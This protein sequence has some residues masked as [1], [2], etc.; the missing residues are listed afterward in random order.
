MPLNFGGFR[1]GD[2]ASAVSAPGVVDWL[3]LFFTIMGF[4]AVIFGALWALYLH[5]VNKLD[6]LAER[7]HDHEVKTAETVVERQEIDK[8]YLALSD[9]IDAQN[10]RIDAHRNG[11][12]DKP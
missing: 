11:R 1:S 9:R 6:K 7:L 3:E 10:R 2:D 8:M 4:G 5:V 12:G